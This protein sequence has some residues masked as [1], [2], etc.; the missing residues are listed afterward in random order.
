VEK[1]GMETGRGEEIE[2]GLEKWGVTKKRENG[3]GRLRSLSGA[4]EMT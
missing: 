4:R 1:G 2:E 3:A